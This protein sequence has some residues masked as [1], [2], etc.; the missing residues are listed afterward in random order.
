MYPTCEPRFGRVTSMSVW[1]RCTAIAS[2]SSSLLSAYASSSRAN[3]S[4]IACTASSAWSRSTLTMIAFAGMREMVTA[5]MVAIAAGVT[6]ADRH[7]WR[8]GASR[9][10]SS[11]SVGGIDSERESS[12]LSSEALARSAHAAYMAAGTAR[13]DG[14]TP[15]SISSCRP[16]AAQA[17]SSAMRCRVYVLGFFS[18]ACCK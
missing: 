8:A 18:A 2:G 16:V 4:C 12:A 3:C 11:T 15:K 14:D 7:G 9:G 1:P 5:G 13:D 10:A 17:A 6:S